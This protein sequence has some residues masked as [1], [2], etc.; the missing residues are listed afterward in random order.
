ML[1]T[2]TLMAYNFVC[3]CTQI[4]LYLNLFYVHMCKERKRWIR[5]I[6]LIILLLNFYQFYG[7]SFTVW[8]TNQRKNIY[9]G[10]AYF[11]KCEVL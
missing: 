10:S 4:Y 2:Y 8:K 6:L 1:Y 11:Q 7:C 5:Y 3:M 9:L